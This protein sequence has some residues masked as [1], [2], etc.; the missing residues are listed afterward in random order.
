MNAVDEI[1]RK[2]GRR[3]IRLLENRPKSNDEKVNP[4]LFS[5]YEATK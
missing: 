2:F 5:L 4:L 1:N 3:T